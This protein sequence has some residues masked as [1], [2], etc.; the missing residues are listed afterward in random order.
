MVGSQ[1]VSLT[2]GPSF[3]H[4]L[5]YKCPN[6]QC[7]AILDIYTSKP[8]Q[9]QKEHPNPRCFGLCYR[10]LNIRESQRIPSPQLWE[11][12]FHPH[13]WP[14]WGCN[15]KIEYQTI[16]YNTIITNSCNIQYNTITINKITINKITTN[17]LQRNNHQ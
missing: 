10:T 6:D 2:P 15:N 14:N 5:G 13:T 16:I 9:W 7:E 4:N 17:G 3:A 11:C 12:E 1:I 8:F